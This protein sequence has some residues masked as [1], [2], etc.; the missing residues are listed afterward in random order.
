MA[1]GDHARSVVIAMQL[2][3][4]GMQVGV[5]FLH[6]GPAPSYTLP[7]ACLIDA[8]DAVRTGTAHHTAVGTAWTNRTGPCI[9]PAVRTFCVLHA[10]AGPG[11]RGWVFEIF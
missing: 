8:C 2:Q 10:V 4:P 6:A 5:S 3:A 7:T 11:F 1:A 9:W